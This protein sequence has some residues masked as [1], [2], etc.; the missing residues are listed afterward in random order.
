MIFLYVF[1]IW[2]ML[3]VHWAGFEVSCKSYPDIKWVLNVLGSNMNIIPGL[4]KTIKQLIRDNV[5]ML[6]KQIYLL[7]KTK[8]PKCYYFW[9]N[10]FTAFRFA[11][12]IKLLIPN[13][14]FYVLKISVI[15]ICS[16][17]CKMMLKRKHLNSDNSNKNI[18]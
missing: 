11:N 5:R 10:F 2:V 16:R 9:L 13:L 7:K 8:C 12:R 15:I 17:W 4:E 14:F 18:I 1:F 6:G 3:I